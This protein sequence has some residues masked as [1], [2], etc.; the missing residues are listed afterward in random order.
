MRTLL[1]LSI[2][3]LLGVAG[4]T[5]AQTVTHTTTASWT[6]PTANTDGSAIS[7]TLTYNVYAGPKGGTFAKVASAITG[8]STTITL[9][10]GSN[11]VAVTAVEG[12]QESDPSTAACVIQPNSPA[13]VAITVT[14][15]IT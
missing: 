11:C 4:I 5:Y 13:G 1:I 10:S 2:L 8:T 14:V 9:P 12:S 15:K 3:F 6:A 7:G